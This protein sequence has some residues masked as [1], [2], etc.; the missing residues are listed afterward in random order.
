ML[1]PFTEATLKTTVTGSKDRTVRVSK[2]QL[3]LIKNL[4]KPSPEL[5]HL[6]SEATILK[7]SFMLF[8]RAMKIRVLNERK[9]W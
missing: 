7:G 8:I 5:E 3:E 2:A 4:Q 9:H 6:A 1:M